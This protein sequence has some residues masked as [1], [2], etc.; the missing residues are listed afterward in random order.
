MFL[1]E[2]GQW[3]DNLSIAPKNSW[4]GNDIAIIGRFPPFICIS[5]VL[6]FVNKI[7]FLSSFFLIDIG[8][9]YSLLGYCETYL[10][11]QLV[12]LRLHSSVPKGT[13]LKMFQF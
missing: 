4:E 6:G 13:P 1:S 10:E 2:R 5:H 3:E 12:I 7:L 8:I 9:L 11:I